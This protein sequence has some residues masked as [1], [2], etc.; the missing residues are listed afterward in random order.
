ME[1]P[2]LAEVWATNFPAVEK[3]AEEAERKLRDF[4]AQVG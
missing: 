3:A 1:F 4:V 2:E